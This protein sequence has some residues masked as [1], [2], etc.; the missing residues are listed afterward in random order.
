[1][2]TPASG[3]IHN[4][5]DKRVVSDIVAP[6]SLGNFP[7]SIECKNVNCSWEFSTLLEGTSVTLNNHWSQCTEDAKREGL[8][9]L[10]VFTKN[11][12]K[13]Y[14]M[15]RQS[16]FQRLNITI[17][18]MLTIELQYIKVVIVSFDKLLESITVDQLIAL[19]IVSQSS[20]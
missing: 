1:M 5:N 4:F 18:P 10:L 14:A 2:R 19:D 6:L 20:Q 3:A 15:M 7:F 16:D 11:F 12:R 9:P 8:I 17:K 13:V